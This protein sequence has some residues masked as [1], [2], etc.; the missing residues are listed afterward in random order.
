MRSW[1]NGN[2][3]APHV[4]R[5]PSPT[6]TKEGGTNSPTSNKINLLDRHRSLSLPSPHGT[7]SSPRFRP[8]LRNNTIQTHE[9]RSIVPITFDS[10][11]LI[12]QH[13]LTSSDRPQP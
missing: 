4:S 1:C 10:F 13:D 7:P 8:H 5:R 11:Y 6:L 2:I 9:H 12:N 3:R